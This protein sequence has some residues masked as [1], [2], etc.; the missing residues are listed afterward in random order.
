MDTERSFGMTKGI[1]IIGTGTD[2]GKTYVT[3]LLVKKLKE[4]GILVGYYKGAISGARF[5]EESDA[6]YVKRVAGLEQEEHT[7]VSYLYQNAVSPH[8][9]SKLEGNPVQLKKVKEDFQKVAEEHDFVVMEGS[10]GIVCP[11]RYD[12]E[13]KI[14][15]EDFIKELGLNTILVAEAGLGTINAVVLTV[16]YLRQKRIGIQGIFINRYTGSE[17]ER[18]NI[19]MI[20]EITKVPVLSVIAPN[21]K[22]ILLE[23]TMID[24]IRKTG[25]WEKEKQ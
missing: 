1:F 4:L 11:I 9:A 16:E 13:E 3:A 20:E 7:L 5:M 24:R 10:G 19:K 21:A 6:G 12:E 25:A 14:F 8:L 2:V 17:M 18:D 23:E 15:L 22:E